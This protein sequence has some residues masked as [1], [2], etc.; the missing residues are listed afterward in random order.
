[1]VQQE[2]RDHGRGPPSI[3]RFVAV[4]TVLSE[5]EFKGGLLPIHK[6]MVEFLNYIKTVGVD[7]VT[8]SLGLCKLEK[9]YDQETRKLC[10][11]GAAQITVEDKLTTIGSAV[12]RLLVSAKV[13]RKAG[14]APPGYMERRIAATLEAKNAH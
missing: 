7:E 13:P 9:A 3:H 5:M 11:S 12:S 6:T 4:L 10:F 8:D 14:R 2:G 1:M